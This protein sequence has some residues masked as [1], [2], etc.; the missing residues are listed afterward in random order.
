MIS[1][2]GAMKPARARGE[3]IVSRKIGFTNSAAWA[4]Y[5]M[6]CRMLKAPFWSLNHLIGPSS[7]VGQ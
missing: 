2:L 5:G 7:M 1:R 6:A 4:G 3:R